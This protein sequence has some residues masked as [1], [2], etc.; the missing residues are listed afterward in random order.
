MKF[1]ISHETSAFYYG[2]IIPW[3]VFVST[4]LLFVFL[5]FTV[6]DKIPTYIL[7]GITI[8][9]VL[10]ELLFALLSIGEKI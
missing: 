1:K 5:G 10:Y 9:C 7:V 8:L 3:F 4:L 2:V 6:K